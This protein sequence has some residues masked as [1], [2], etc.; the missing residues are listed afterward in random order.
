MSMKAFLNASAALA[1]TGMVGVA[2]AG[3]ASA[4]D[5]ARKAPPPVTKAPPPPAY[6]PYNWTGFYVGVNGGYGFGRS[7]WSGLP[8]GFDVKGGMFGGQLGYNWQFGQFV[9]GLEGD[10]DW[11]D[12][13]GA[14]RIAACG[15]MMCQ[16]KNDYLSTA[17]GR[18]G[19]AA[20]RWLPYATAGLAVGNIHATAPGFAGIDKTNAGWTAGGGFEFALVGNWTA[21]AEYLYVD[22]G[23]DG[24]GVMCGLPMGNNVSLTSNV[25]R[26]G[27]NYRF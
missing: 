19:F 11:T 7:K 13:R 14:A 21:K 25:V 16:T 22:L 6:L 3:T 2:A 5:L 12:L 9:Y 15:M 27:I 1:L 4:A 18:I 20:D 10:A 17:R 8:S 23:K 26:A 24:C